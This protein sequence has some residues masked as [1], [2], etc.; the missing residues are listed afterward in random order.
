MPNFPGWEFTI[1]FGGSDYRILH[2]NN[3][4]LNVTDNELK[5]ELQVLD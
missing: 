5:F 2:P 1:N 4:N 3:K